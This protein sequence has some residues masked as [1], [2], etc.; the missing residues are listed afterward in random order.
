MTTFKPGLTHTPV[1]PFTQ[2]GRID[3]DVYS[4]LIAFHLD[5][6]AESLALPMHAGESVSLSDDER[7]RLLEFAVGQVG[8]RV[9]VIAHVSQSGTGIAAGLA[10]HAADA[11]AAAVVATTPYYW[12]PPAGMLLEHFTRIGAAADIPFFVY[13]SPQEMGGVKVTTDLVLKLVDRLDNFI[14]VIDASLDWQFMIEV[15]SSAQQVRPEFQLLT[16]SEYMISA[17][18]IGAVGMLSPLAG[19]APK[20]VRLLWDRC[21]NEDY[22]AARPVQEAIAALRQAVKPW[23]VAGIKGGMQVMQRGCGQ[24]RP[25]LDPL[26]AADMEKIA[27]GIDAIALL[28]GEPRGWR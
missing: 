1:T 17:G 9:P 26:D 18:A 16:G 7:R 10:S 8:G 3:E 15:I 24:P 19:I 20:A 28:R 11:G 2:E 6:G 4:K 25:P 23:E 27:A 12:T 22:E 21:R 13:N 14:G 5:H